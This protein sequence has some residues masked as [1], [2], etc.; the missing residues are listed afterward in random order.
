MGK[1]I[2]VGDIFNY[3]QNILIHINNK[4]LYCSFWFLL[5]VVN[6][7]IIHSFE[8]SYKNYPYDCEELVID[9]E[10]KNI[11]ECKDYFIFFQAKILQSKIILFYLWLYHIIFAL[12]V[13]LNNSFNKFYK[14]HDINLNIA[15]LIIYCSSSFADKKL[16]MLLNMK[17]CT[18]MYFCEFFYVFTEISMMIPIILCVIIIIYNACFLCC[19]LYENKIKNIEIIELPNDPVSQLDKVA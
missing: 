9:E 4:Y 7:A 3:I 10:F 6:S 5:L 11:S 14:N 2:R 13:I 1:K 12:F 8:L 16:I 18:V 17:Q 19:N 15:N